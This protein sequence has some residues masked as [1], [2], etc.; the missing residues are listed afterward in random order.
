VEA[1][2]EGA[3][4]DCETLIAKLKDGPPSA[5]VK[6]VAVDWR[7]PTGKHNGFVITY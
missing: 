3:K 5:R 4:A 6:E 2:I 7:E 1:L